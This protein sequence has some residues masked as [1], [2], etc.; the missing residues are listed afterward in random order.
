MACAPLDAT[1]KERERNS[2]TLRQEIAIRE[3][4]CGLY[5]GMRVIKLG[6]LPRR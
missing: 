2:V 6:D 5:F 4:V 3:L 1:N